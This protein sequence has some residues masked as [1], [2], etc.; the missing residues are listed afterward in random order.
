MKLE[1]LY[2]GTKFKYIA[3]R[4]LKEGFG[5]WSYFAKDLNTAIG[6]GG[7]YVFEVIFVKSDIPDY[8]QV[9]CENNVS[10][11][12]IKRFCKYKETEIF[13]DNRLQNK[14]FDNAIEYGKTKPYVFKE[15]NNTK[16]VLKQIL[17]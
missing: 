8:W 4:I 3:D 10:E 13:K 7:K 16:K 12:R 1:V 6:Q 5:E 9:R 15:N 17:I 2:H 14:V 11:K